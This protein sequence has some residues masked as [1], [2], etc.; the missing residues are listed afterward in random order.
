MTY[1]D[2]IGNLF[3]DP[4]NDIV[5]LVGCCK[6]PTV[7]FEDTYGN[8]TGGAIGS[9]LVEKY[10]KLETLNNDR[11]IKLVKSLMDRVSI[12]DSKLTERTNELTDTKMKYVD[13]KEKLFELT[14]I[15]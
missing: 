7:T 8:Q 5:T 1:E 14:N 12:L 9:L 10:K 4:S 3:V 6:Y 2:E 13:L 11:L 15:E